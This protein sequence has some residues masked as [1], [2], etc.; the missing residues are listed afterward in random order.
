MVLICISLILSDVEHLFMCLLAICMS[1]L[2][3][4]LFSS[5][6]HFLIG[7]FVFLVL[8]CTNCLYILEIN[9]LSVVSSAII[10]SHSEGCLFTLL[11]VFFNVQKLLSLIELPYNPAIPLL[12][13]Y[14]E[15]TRIERDTCTPV[16]IA[17]LLTIARTWK[18]SICSLADER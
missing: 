9:F 3:K 2:E 10:F 13:I 16:F 17:A 4:C 18:Q 14:P 5:F 8:S 15:E 1:S 12:G 7:L 11:I 6:A